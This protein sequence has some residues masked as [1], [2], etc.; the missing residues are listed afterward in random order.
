MQRPPFG[1]GAIYRE[2]CRVAREK[3][4]DPPGYHTVYSVIRAIPEDLKTLA[5]DG[6]KAYRNAYDLVHR[7]EAERPNQIWQADHT[8][9]DL[10]AIRDDGQP[11]RPWLSIIIDDHSRAIAGFSF[12]FNSPST[13][14]T[15]LVLRQ[16][17]WRKADA[18]WIVFGIPTY[19]T[20]TT[21]AIS[22]RSTSSRL[23]PI[24]S[25]VSSFPHLGIRVAAA[26]SSVFSRPSTRCSSAIYLATSA[27][28]ALSANLR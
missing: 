22:R 16:A 19:S 18:H 3:G 1:P 14:L 9:L 27:R 8:Q 6:E 26:A 20:R 21:A 2:V 24:S 13:L 15:S 10:W 23:P 11:D 17:I 7:R 12:S 5:I 28:A 4:Q 25:C